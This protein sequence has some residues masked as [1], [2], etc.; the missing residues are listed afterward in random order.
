MIKYFTAINHKYYMLTLDL[1]IKPKKDPS[2]FLA[3]FLKKYEIKGWV[4]TLVLYHIIIYSIQKIFHLHTMLI[5]ILIFF[6]LLPLLLYELYLA[7]YFITSK[8][9]IIKMTADAKLIL[10]E[11]EKKIKIKLH[12]KK[13]KF[14]YF[15]HFN[16]KKKFTGPSLKFS[17]KKLKLDIIIEC[18]CQKEIIQWK[19][20]QADFIPSQ[21]GNVMLDENKF[22]ELLKII[23]LNKKI[24]SYRIKK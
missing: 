23:K 22:M 6:T 3:R 7:F 15:H 18:G 8:K 16:N 14:Q 24:K 19:K 11:I 10:I 1:K 4:V 13:T 9:N 21:T 17:V 5:S 2:N 12:I 20:P